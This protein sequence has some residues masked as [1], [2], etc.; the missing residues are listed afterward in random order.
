MLARLAQMGY[1]WVKI[2]DMNRIRNFISYDGDNPFVPKPK[3]KPVEKPKD[4]DPFE[5]LDSDIE[6]KR[7]MEDFGNYAGIGFDDD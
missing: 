5:K 4:I 7:Y 1:I 6:E 2:N 3:P